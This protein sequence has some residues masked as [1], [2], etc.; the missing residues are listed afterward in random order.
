M[1]CMLRNKQRIH[2]AL[3]ESK[4]EFLD[5]YGNRTGSFKI[6][7][8]DPLPLDI[9]VS[10][11][12]RGEAESEMF[13]INTDYTKTMVTDRDIGLN[14]NSILWIEKDPY[15]NVDFVSE[16]ISEFY[17]KHG[18][19]FNG[20]QSIYLTDY[21]EAD[22]IS[23]LE[24]GEYIPYSDLEV[25][26]IAIEGGEVIYK[27]NDKYYSLSGTEVEYR[28]LDDKVIT[29]TPHN[30]VIVRVAK[31]LSSITYAIKEVATCENQSQ[32]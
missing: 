1:R 23:G 18:Y 17:D 12:K 2:Y 10:P 24:D 21:L 26:Q 13:G 9:N 20:G 27:H 5:E 22:D 6:N 11:A 15:V 16:K 7:Y 8:S 3:F 4:E 14:V 31:G 25:C 19:M 29:Q 32:S 28:D 30:Y